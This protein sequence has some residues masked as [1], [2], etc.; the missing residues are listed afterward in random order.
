ME[1]NDKTKI[2]LYSVLGTVPFIIGGIMWL[3]VI[4]VRAETSEKVNEKQDQK[5]EQ[6]QSLLIDIRD[7]VREIKAQLKRGR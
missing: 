4:S 2:P 3:T 1:I 5:L 6:Q 7:D